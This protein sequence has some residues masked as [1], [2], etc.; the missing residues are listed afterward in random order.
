VPSTSTTKRDHVQANLV[1]RPGQ[2]IKLSLDVLSSIA[3]K[4]STP[5]LVL[6]REMRRLRSKATW[7][8]GQSPWIVLLNPLVEDWRETCQGTSTESGD[9]DSTVQYDD[10]QTSLFFMDTEMVADDHAVE[11]QKRSK[12]QFNLT[13]QQRTHHLRKLPQSWVSCPENTTTARARRRRCRRLFGADQATFPDHEPSQFKIFAK[14]TPS[15][16]ESGWSCASRA[17]FLVKWRA[18][19]KKVAESRH[20]VGPAAIGRPSL[21]YSQQWRSL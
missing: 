20:A 18:R 12:L 2:T 6:S 5:K 10:L 21:H 1:S 9:W 15:G 3:S 17:F 8:N 11:H 13:P 7:Y 16:C 19:C 4:T 14:G